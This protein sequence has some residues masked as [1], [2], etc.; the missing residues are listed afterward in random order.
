[1]PKDERKSHELY[2]TWKL[3]LLCFFNIFVCVVGLLAYQF[4]II[5]GGAYSIDLFS[6]CRY[7]QLVYIGLEHL[8]LMYSKYL[9]CICDVWKLRTYGKVRIYP[10]EKVLRA[11][12]TVVMATWRQQEQQEHSLWTMVKRIAKLKFESSKPTIWKWVYEILNRL[13][14]FG[15]HYSVWHVIFWT[16]F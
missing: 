13:W 1:M 3:F 15:N 12:F 14:R 11:V 7:S 5:I 6:C 10:K 9:M 16:P 8:Q 2:V 4:R